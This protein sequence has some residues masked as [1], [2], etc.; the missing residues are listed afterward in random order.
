MIYKDRHNLK[1]TI[2]LILSVI[3]LATALTGCSVRLTSEQKAACQEAD[4]LLEEL[5]ALADNNGMKSKTKKLDG[6]IVYIATIDFATSITVGNARTFKSHVMPVL[7]NILHPEDIYVVLY[8]N[9][10]G[11]ELYRL[12]DSQLDPSILD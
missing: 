12:I 7:E 11:E 3:I 5:A 6:K 8:L 1:K 2:S 9:E 10:N 4:E